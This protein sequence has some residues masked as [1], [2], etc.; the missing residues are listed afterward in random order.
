MPLKQG[1]TAFFNW[2]VESFVWW[3]TFYAVLS[4]LYTCGHSYIEYDFIAKNK[5]Q[6]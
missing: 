5:N 3:L 6:K 2:F 1:Q 4:N